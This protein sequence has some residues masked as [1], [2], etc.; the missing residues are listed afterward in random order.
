V[1]NAGKNQTSW[2]RLFRI[3]CD[4][5]R[6]VNADGQII[7]HWTL[8]GGTA[9]MLQ[10]DHRESHDVDIF[11]GDPQLLPYL[12]P[13]KHDFRFDI[14]PA[15]YSGDG[16]GF[17]KISFQDIGEIDFIVDS[18]KTSNPT[19]VR[20][21]EGERTLLETIPEIITKKIVHR[22]ESIKARDIFDIA[23][24]GE[25]HRDSIVAELR[26]Y[27]P[28]VAKTLDALKAL[29]PEFVN[30]VIADLIIRENFQPLAQV[31][32][33]RAKHLLQAV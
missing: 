15:D 11:L 27:R 6:Q 31:A 12:D 25:A 26:S 23:A 8:G 16:T 1:T 13:Q 14:K 24:A 32:L 10:I 30:N 22:G 17:L 28:E 20:E 21:I 9:M 2:A 7:D 5:I 3:A 19:V 33:H 29:K 18:P 4:L